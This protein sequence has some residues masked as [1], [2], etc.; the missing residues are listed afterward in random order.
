MMAYLTIASCSACES[1][2]TTNAAS[3]F[4]A[5]TALTITGI[6]FLLVIIFSVA[7]LAFLIW[8]I[9][10]LIDCANRDFP[11]KNTWLIILILSF[12]LGFIWLADILYYYMVV[13]KRK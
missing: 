11:D 7:Y 2:T 12:V 1:T 6:I 5:Q 9:I 3:A 4:A 8:W 10:L 13:K